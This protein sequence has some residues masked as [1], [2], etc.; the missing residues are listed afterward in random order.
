[1]SFVYPRASEDTGDASVLSDT[2]VADTIIMWREYGFSTTRAELEAL[3]LCH[4]KKQVKEVSAKIDEEIRA[5]GSIDI[6][7]C[8]TVNQ[9]KIE[10]QKVASKLVADDWIKG[11]RDKYEVETFAELKAALM[12][13]EV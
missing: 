10:I 3:C 4:N 6:A 1:M 7:K 8:N 11:L 5:L 12:P 13:K 2:E 9:F